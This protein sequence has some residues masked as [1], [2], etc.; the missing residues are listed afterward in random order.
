MIFTATQKKK[1][2]K[3]NSDDDLQLSKKKKKYK[4]SPRPSRSQAIPK[5]NGE[6]QI[7]PPFPPTLTHATIALALELIETN[8]PA[9]IL[10]H[11]QN[12][13]LH[14]HAINFYQQPIS[15]QNT[16]RLIRVPCN[17]M[18]VLEY[19]IVLRDCTQGRPDNWYNCL[20]T[21]CYLLDVF[22]PVPK[23]SVIDTV[24]YSGLRALSLCLLSLSFVFY[25]IKF[26]IVAFNV[27]IA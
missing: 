2:N 15:P 27:V 14:H 24:C 21:V 9:F 4:I 25:I 11:S 20:K 6:T 1:N 23:A 7:P 10:V 19:S 12:V 5:L 13:L 17:A 8:G 22:L 26:L 18:E 3:S 16:R